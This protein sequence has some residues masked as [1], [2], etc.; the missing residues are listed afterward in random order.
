MACPPA[1]FHPVTYQRSAASRS[2]RSHNDAQPSRCAALEK[3]RQRRTQ[4]SVTNA[5]LAIGIL[6]TRKVT[7]SN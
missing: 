5:L 4:A 7:R 6:R 1:K 2:A 3:A